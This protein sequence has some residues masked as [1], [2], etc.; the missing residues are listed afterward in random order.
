MTTDDTMRRAVEDGAQ[1]LVG[2]NISDMT[3]DDIAEAAIRAALPIIGDEL[4]KVAKIIGL[5]EGYD[6]GNRDVADFIA[7]QQRARLAEMLGE[8]G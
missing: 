7:T 6:G 8:K 2:L 5:D 4:V 1:A 3:L